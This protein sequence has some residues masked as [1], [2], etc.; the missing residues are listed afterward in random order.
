MNEGRIT[1]EAVQNDSRD[2]VSV[3]EGHN[4]HRQFLR[5]ARGEG[6]SVLIAQLDKK[7]ALVTG[8]AL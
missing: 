5:L 8:H 3:Q 7:L 4:A 2:H 6:I 1:A